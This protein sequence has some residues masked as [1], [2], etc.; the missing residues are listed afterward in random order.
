MTPRA[1]RDDGSE[2]GSTLW[3]GLSDQLWDLDTGTV[4][5]YGYLS[6]MIGYG[7]GR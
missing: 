5:L 3:G 1:G 2:N 4:A 6:E 7:G